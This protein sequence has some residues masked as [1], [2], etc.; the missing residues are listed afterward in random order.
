VKCLTVFDEFTRECLAIDVAGSI[1]SARVMEVLTQLMSDRGAL[2]Y[3]R[4][5]N[6]SEF[7]SKAAGERAYAAD[8]TGHRLRCGSPHTMTCRMSYAIRKRILK[9]ATRLSL[10]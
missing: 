1:R 6:G 3:L 7:V 8:H 5:D 10:R 2:R 9:K 4:S